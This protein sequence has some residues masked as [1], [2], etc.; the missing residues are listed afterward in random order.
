MEKL[1]FKFWD[2]IAERFCND[3]DIF[4]SSNGDVYQDCEN[5]MLLVPHAVPLQFTGLTD[6]NGVE[7]Y[8]GDIV[9][10]LYH[11]LDVDYDENGAVEFG[12]THDSDGWCCGE[13]YG[14]VTT[15][16]SSLLDLTECE[17]SGNI[18]ENPELLKDGS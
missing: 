16:G 4:I 5:E 17:I 1:K 8:E 14:W 12:I 3:D 6:K 15:N 7:I 9:S 11:N 10:G 18:Y 13:T 2:S